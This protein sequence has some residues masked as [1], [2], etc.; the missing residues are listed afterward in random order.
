VT[1]EAEPAPSEVE[2]EVLAALLT[3]PDARDAVQ[4]WARAGRVLPLRPSATFGRVNE[5]VLRFWQPTIET[6]EPV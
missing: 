6:N 5:T 2:N 4:R 1:G 3:G